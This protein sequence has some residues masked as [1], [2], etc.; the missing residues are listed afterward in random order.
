NNCQ[1]TVTTDNKL[2]I[3]KHL[4]GQTWVI[5]SN[6]EL[7]FTIVCKDQRM[8]DIIIHYPL[9]VIQLSD[10]CVA[11]NK[12]LTL[13]AP[14]VIN[15]PVELKDNDIDLLRSVNW[16]SS[17]VWAP[18]VTSLPKFPKLNLPKTL[19]DIKEFPLDTLINEL[20]TVNDVKVKKGKTWPMWAYLTLIVGGLSLV[21][22]L[23]LIVY[24]Y[25]SKMWGRKLSISLC[26][27]K[28]CDCNSATRRTAEPEPAST[29]VVRQGRSDRN[30]VSPALVKADDFIQHLYP[31]IDEVTRL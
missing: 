8:D 7:R 14:Y 18:F 11:S 1:A 21:L 9:D 22:S 5:A 30:D 12:Y 24:V 10:K 26:L 13:A 17:L 23:I 4:I 16:T 20:R 29:Y 27:S 28:M 15:T 31:I 3:A 25:A 2:P 19:N 6:K